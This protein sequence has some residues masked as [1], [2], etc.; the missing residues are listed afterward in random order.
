MESSRDD[1][2]IAL[3]SAFLKKGAQQRFSL[4]SLIFFSIIF[5]VLGS[6]NFK[7]TNYVKIAIEEIVYRSSFIVSVPEN[8]L[9]DSYLTIQNHL[10]L[11]KVNEKNISEL[12]ELKSKNIFKS[13]IEY[14]NMN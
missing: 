2:V 6:F 4:L 7:I 9:K 3:R 5:L 13:I 14:E 8:L 10:N 1:F 11:Y 12:K